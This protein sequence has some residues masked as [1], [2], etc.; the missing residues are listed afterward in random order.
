[1]SLPQTS[2]MT[3]AQYL[4]REHVAET[5]SEFLNGQVLAM[6]GTSWPHN[7]IVANLQGTLLPQLRT[8]GCRGYSHDMRVAVKTQDSYFYPD[9][10]AYCGAREEIQGATATLLNPILVIEVLSPSTEGYDRGMK[11][12]HYQQISSLQQYV[13]VAQ[14]RPLVE[15]YTRQG[16][17]SWRY[18]AFSGL[19]ATASMVSV[20]A[21][22]PLAELYREVSFAA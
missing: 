1:M 3:A 17:G 16:D 12:F 21:T 19:A 9:F 20:E 8:R 18:D 11:F 10:V 7:D 13:L 2:S 5:R 4:E 14:E 22:V 15:V 6:A